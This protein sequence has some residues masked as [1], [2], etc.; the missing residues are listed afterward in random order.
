VD[1]ALPAEPL[2]THC[3]PVSFEAVIAETYKYGGVAG[4]VSQRDLAITL[5]GNTGE[6]FTQSWTY[7]DLGDVASVTWASCRSTISTATRR[8]ASRG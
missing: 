2:R 5:N 1:G 8:R 3:Q 4:R 6:T 7:T